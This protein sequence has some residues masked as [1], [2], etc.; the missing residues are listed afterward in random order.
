M[1]PTHG[2]DTAQRVQQISQGVLRVARVLFDVWSEEP[3]HPTQDIDLLGFGTSL[4]S[5]L[6][7]VFREICEVA[8]GEDWLQSQARAVCKAEFHVDFVGDSVTGS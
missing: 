2:W 7:K 6:E 5:E 4:I 3:H 1:G 8:A